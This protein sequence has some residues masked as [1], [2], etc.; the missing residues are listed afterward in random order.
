[1]VSFRCGE[2]S[3]YS[4]Y[5]STIELKQK[6]VNVHSLEYLGIHKNECQSALHNKKY[7]PEY[8]LHELFARPS[9]DMKEITS[10]L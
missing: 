6:G 5:H 3:L 10:I 9:Y 4:T 7:V 2:F 1:M 8:R